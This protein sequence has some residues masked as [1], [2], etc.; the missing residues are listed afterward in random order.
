MIRP[1]QRECVYKAVAASGTAE[2]L[3]TFKKMFREADRAEERRLMIKVVSAFTNPDLIQ[4]G[5]PHLAV[6]NVIRLAQLV[7]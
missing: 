5:V 3:D 7:L 4:V 6:A 2:H 1:D